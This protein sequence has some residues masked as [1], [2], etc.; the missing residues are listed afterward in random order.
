MT[1]GDDPRF[2]QTAHL[3][4]WSSVEEMRAEVEKWR[5][6]DCGISASLEERAPGHFVMVMDH[7]ESC[8]AATGITGG[9]G[10]NLP[11]PPPP[12]S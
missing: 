11:S 10:D 4:E 12:S 6:P 2:D 8:P 7:Q 1:V 9:A 5:C 3:G